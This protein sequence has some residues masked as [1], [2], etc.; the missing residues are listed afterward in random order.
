MYKY[1]LMNTQLV[2]GYHCSV[3]YTYIACVPSVYYTR[4]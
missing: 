2:V 1:L 4:G 3:V